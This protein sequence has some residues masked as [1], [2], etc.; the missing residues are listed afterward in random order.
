MQ[1]NIIQVLYIPCLI[2]ICKRLENPCYK[3]M[4]M[5]GALDVLALFICT[6]ITAVFGIIGVVYCSAPNFIYVLGS[7]ALCNVLFNCL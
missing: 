5:M 7:C 6:I 1:F 4:F 3:F 2:A